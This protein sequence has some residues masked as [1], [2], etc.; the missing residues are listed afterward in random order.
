MMRLLLPV[1]LLLGGCAAAATA[2]T[3]VPTVFGEAMAYFN[4]QNVSL[5][6]DMQ[7]S[8]A[9]LQRGL[10]RMSL[11]VDVLEAV[12]EGYAVEFGNGELNGDIQLQRQTAQLTTLN[13]KVYRGLAHQPSV[14]MTIIDEVRSASENEGEGAHFDFTGYDKIYA[15]PEMS[16]ESLGW[17]RSGAKLHV[18]TYDKAGWLKITLPSG[19]EAYIRGSMQ[20]SGT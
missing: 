3:A 16:I 12:D 13:I 1:L 8:L 7:H 20:D 14:E 17:F 9:A 15:K 2:V 19:G 10:E 4:G 18:S 5:A 6:L 11:H